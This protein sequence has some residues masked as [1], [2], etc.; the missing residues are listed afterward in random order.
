MNYPNLNNAILQELI[1]VEWKQRNLTVLVKRD[2]LIHNEISGN[3]WRKLLY[4]FEQA[5]FNKNDT[6]LTFGGAFSNH[7]VATA[8]AC[9]LLGFNSIGIVRGDELNENSNDTLKRCSDYGMQLVFVS[10]S[11]Y[12]LRYDREWWK[13]LH[14]DYPNSFIVPEGGANYYGI[15]GCQE[16]WSELP[17][18]VDRVFVAQ[19]TTTTSCGILL[20]SLEKCKVHVVPVLKGFD[21]EVEMR[22]LFQQSFL[23]EELISEFF[24]RLVIEKD[25]HFGGYGKYTDE[26]LT[27]I[28]TKYRQFNLKLDPIYTAKAF[29]ALEDTIQKLNLRDEK[30]VFIHTGGIQGSK[31]VEMREKIDLYTA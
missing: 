13:E 31:E 8:C 25:Y 23:E 30:I 29:Y 12:Q 10:R 18:D 21:S 3:K 2:D 15:L 28:T 24:D 20:G 4:N 22:Q 11:E 7:L 27:Y 1:S 26:L 17:K 19:G 9:N 14:I 6:I 5:K 16:I